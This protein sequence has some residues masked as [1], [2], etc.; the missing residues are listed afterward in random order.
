MDTTGKIYVVERAQEQPLHPIR[1]DALD[2]D[3][4]YA[5]KADS[6]AALRAT[7]N[8]TQSWS[9]IRGATAISGG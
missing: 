9:A 6:L 1:V 5:P 8:V 4:H 7:R 3:E 2:V